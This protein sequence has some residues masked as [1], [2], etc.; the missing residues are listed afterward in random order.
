MVMVIVQFVKVVEA[1]GAL[2]ECCLVALTVV[3]T[4]DDFG[5]GISYVRAIYPF[6]TELCSPTHVLQ[7][8]II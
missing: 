6:V 5:Y 8:S 3:M 7:P 2:A 4:V 1:I